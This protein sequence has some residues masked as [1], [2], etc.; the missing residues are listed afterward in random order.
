MVI[1]IDAVI[2]FGQNKIFIYL[3]PEE[4]RYIEIGRK[5]CTWNVLSET[6]SENLPAG[7]VIIVENAHL[8]V[9]RVKSKAQ[10][11][12]E[13][14]LLNFYADLE[15]NGLILKLFPEKQ[16]SKAQA[17][18]GLEKTDKN[19]P[20]TIYIYSRDHEGVYKSLKNP[21]KNFH[22]TGELKKKEGIEFQNS[23]SDQLNIARNYDYSSDFSTYATEVLDEGLDGEIK[24]I[25]W[26]YDNL[27]EIKNRL[28]PEAIDAFQL[29][30]EKDDKLIDIYAMTS[31]LMLPNGEPRVR[32]H[33][34][35]TAG[36]KYIKQYVI[37]AKPNKIK[38]GVLSSN[39]YHH[40]IKAYTA[41]K[42]DN[43][44][45]KVTMDKQSGK[46]KM[47]TSGEVRMSTVYKPLRDYTGTVN[48]PR[49]P[50]N[51]QRKRLRNLYSNVYL[52]ELYTTIRDMMYS[53]K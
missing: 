17:Y 3:P 50:E 43:K 12:I 32:K 13:S 25:V 30:Q 1:K 10:Y 4:D 51:L 49:D 35:G 19:D 21:L 52:K 41:R 47:M 44:I 33:T 16:T 37:C 2:D 39:I 26:M 8:G 40:R 23:V 42:L 28:S 29:D 14:D 7:S 34:G 11:F 48:S 24:S 15:K 27:Q 20:K 53:N 5:Q 9:P 6:L 45:K 46:P 36:W 18:S 22:G 31:S 38:S